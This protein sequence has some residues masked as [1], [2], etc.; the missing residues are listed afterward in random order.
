[1]KKVLVVNVNWLG[2]NILS[3]PIFKA[4]KEKF[5]VAVMIPSRVKDLYKNNY[6]DEI[7]VFDERNEN[8]SLLSKLKFIRSLRSKKF[9]IAFFLHRSFTKVFICFLAGIKER[10]GYSR[11]KNFFI[12][13]KKI[14]PKD[15]LSIHRQDYYF[16]LFESYGIHIKD[17]DPFI[18]IDENIKEN[19][20][21]SIDKKYSYLIGINLGSNWELKSWP[22][23]NFV[24]L[25][26]LLI[27][28]LNCVILF[29]G[30]EKDLETAIYI[31]NSVKDKSRIYN[32]CGKT[33]LT[34]LIATLS[35]LDLFVSADSGPAH[36]ATALKRKT[37]VL[38][39]P[40][41]EKLTAPRSGCVY[42]IRKELN[43]KIP[44]YD[45]SCK[46]NLCMKK[47]TPEDVFSKVL[48]VLKNG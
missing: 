20:K 34:K 18:Y 36:L 25:I 35:L 41:S 38:F 19:I 2:D 28:N 45:L 4:L 8:K 46:D 31:I 26:D 1:M 16:Y 17:R 22:K 39:G 9:D 21:R 29:T 27:E 43:C 3:L 15:P 33:D 24:K 10:V 6:V 42:I 32:F 13:T 47:I 40:T 30:L 11:F 5:Y 12:L 37:I 7:I 23:E 48:E 14:K 44:C